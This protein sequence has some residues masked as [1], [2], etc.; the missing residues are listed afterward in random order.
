MCACD[1]PEFAAA[2]GGSSGDVQRSGWAAADGGSSGD[3][4]LS[5][6][7]YP[8]IVTEEAVVEADPAAME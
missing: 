3:V 1:F 7:W 5:G 6:C 8:G 2:D 4:Q